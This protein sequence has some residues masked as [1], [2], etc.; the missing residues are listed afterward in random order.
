MEEFPFTADEWGRVDA[1]AGEIVNA[2]YADDAAVADSKLF[3][4]RD[5]L[6]ELRGRHG[7]HPILLETEADYCHDE[8]ESLRLYRE[9]LRLAI[10][11]QLP[12]AS[13]CLSLARALIDKDGN[14]SEIS[15]LLKLCR[16]EVYAGSDSYEI[17]EF[18]EL[19]KLLRGADLGTAQAEWN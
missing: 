17:G 5:L 8:Q 2:S 16:E 9:A 6:E 4:M 13:I 1:L 15:H 10:D 7:E 18:E 19:D 12:I 14:A 3:D 11:N